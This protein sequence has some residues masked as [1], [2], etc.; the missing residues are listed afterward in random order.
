MKQ[1]TINNDNNITIHASAQK[2]DAVANAERF[3]TSAGLAKLAEKWPATRL[4]EI[5]NSLPGATPVK[6]FTDRKTA[7][8]RIWKAIQGLGET[9]TAKSG[10][11]EVPA[12]EMT[13]EMIE[14]AIPAEFLMS[15]PIPIGSFIRQ[16]KHCKQTV[17][18]EGVRRSEYC[19]DIVPILGS[20]GQR[21]F[22]RV[23]NPDLSGSMSGF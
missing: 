23:F 16:H 5:Y 12:T 4:V 11:A 22:C 6:K 17:A 9:P 14:A 19:A 20:G 21:G 7:A 8:T 15:S 13:P 3:S 10:A 2:A 18:S 1:F